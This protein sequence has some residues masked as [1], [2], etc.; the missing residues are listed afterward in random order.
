MAI[1][2]FNRFENKYMLD[3]GTFEKLEKSLWEYMCLDSYNKD[4]ETYRITNLYYDTPDSHLIRTSLQKPKYKEKLRLRAYGTPTIEEK[5]YVEIKKKV[6]GRVN[7]RRSALLL[8]EAYDFLHSGTLPEERPDQNQQVLHE[9]GYLLNTHPLK[10]SLY[11]SYD[12]RA[13]F[14]VRDK[15]L[16]ISF[17]CNI[18]TR[19]HDLTLEAGDQGTPLLG[20]DCWLMEIKVTDSIPIWLCQLLS[21]HKI[22]PT[23]FSKYG[24]EYRK[25]LKTTTSPYSLYNT[26]PQ[27]ILVTTKV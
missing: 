5:V 13:F 27:R 26:K 14:G 15:G 8:K 6:V 20:N 11:L 19:R 17:D 7:K 4:H 25:S 24:A 18:R 9:I 2:I 3:T 12:R 10:P 16:R 23:S 21:E 1:E 22:Y